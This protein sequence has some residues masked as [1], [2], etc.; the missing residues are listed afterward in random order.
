VSQEIWNQQ[1]RRR[2]QQREEMRTRY[3]EHATPATRTP[4]TTR[5][6]HA[7]AGHKTLPAIKLFS[8]LP[9]SRPSLSMPGYPSSHDL[10]YGAWHIQPT[11]TTSFSSAPA[12][13]P[14]HPHAARTFASASSNQLRR[15]GSIFLGRISSSSLAA[16]T[17]ASAS[18][19]QLRRLRVLIVIYPQQPKRNQQKKKETKQ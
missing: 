1:Q 12:T 13:R 19:N 5:Q 10:P 4:N 3:E 15:L 16:R 6:P 11:P 14:S 18:S 17:S 8:M 7:T 9:T 2:R